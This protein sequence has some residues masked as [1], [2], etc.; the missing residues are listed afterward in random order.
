MGAGGWFYVPKVW[1]PY[2]GWWSNPTHWKRNT[3]IAGVGIVCVATMLFSVSA[4][5]ERRPV[6]PFRQI[7]SQSWCKHAKTDDP[8]LK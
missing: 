5:R 1:T 2:G 6:A 7:P 3:G 8:R 4:E